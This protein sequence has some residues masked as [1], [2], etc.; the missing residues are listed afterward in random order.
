[1]S[2]DQP[3]S[4]G[5]GVLAPCLPALPLLTELRFGTIGCMPS[6]MDAQ[7]FSAGLLSLLR[8][9]HGASELCCVQLEYLDV[10]VWSVHAVHDPDV[11]H[12]F[13]L[14]CMK[15][16]PPVHRLCTSW[17]RWPSL[18]IHRPPHNSFTDVGVCMRQRHMH[19]RTCSATW[20]F[21]P[22]CPDH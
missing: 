4:G 3:M 22:T 12:S 7:D 1:M 18:R 13:S 15:H 2:F 20:R 9:M 10:Q 14:M 11:C 5:G 8:S 21:R 17:P 19:V 6:T 16:T